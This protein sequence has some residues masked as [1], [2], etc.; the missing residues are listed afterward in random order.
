MG[1]P[2]RNPIEEIRLSKDHILL[3]HL[4]IESEPWSTL[5]QV[6]ACLI[7]TK[8]IT[9]P[10]DVLGIIPAG[11][12][13]ASVLT[14]QFRLEFC[15]VSLP[16]MHQWYQTYFVNQITMGNN[17]LLKQNLNSRKCI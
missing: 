6:M 15:N 4:Y 8:V 10:A 2:I 14:T 7:N 13:A 16:V 12:S 3:R 17:R 9:A 1:F 11:P 5:F